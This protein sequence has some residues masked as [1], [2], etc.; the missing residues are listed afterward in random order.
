M[1]T[2]QF[3]CE[4]S[5]KQNR[6][7]NQSK[8]QRLS[9]VMQHLKNVSRTI[10]ENTLDHFQDTVNF[11]VGYT[12]DEEFENLKNGFDEIITNSVSVLTSSIVTLL[13]QEN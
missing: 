2:S 10:M 6:N 13:H 5:E 12:L 4:S 8:R 9:Y 11:G 7:D 3:G 1:D